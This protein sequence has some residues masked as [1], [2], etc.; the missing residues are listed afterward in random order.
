MAA[1]FH[2]YIGNVVK[3]SIFSMLQSAGAGGWGAVVLNWL[4][5]LFGQLMA[6]VSALGWVWLWLKAKVFPDGEG[7]SLSN[8]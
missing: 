4:I 8:L 5:S 1:L 3:G 7:N 2:S 6:A